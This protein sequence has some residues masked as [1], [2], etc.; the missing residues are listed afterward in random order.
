MLAG[1]PPTVFFFFTMSSL[2]QSRPCHKSHT[3]FEPPWTK[4]WLEWFSTTRSHNSD[5][6]VLVICA[7]KDHSGEDVTSKTHERILTEINKML[8]ALDAWLIAMGTSRPQ[9]EPILNAVL[10]ENGILAQ[11]IS[12]WTATVFPMASMVRIDRQE[13]I[14]AI[15]RLRSQEFSAWLLAQPEPSAE[16]LHSL[17]LGM[18][19]MLPKLGHHFLYS[20]KVGPR[21]RHGGRDPLLTEEQ[22]KQIPTEV[23][24]HARAEFQTGSN[25]QTLGIEI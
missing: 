17:L 4:T 14:G 10:R 18:R 16:E 20:G 11:F 6:P 13:A 19:D 22:K 1:W 23:K 24:A 21:Y 25:L 12:D 8:A 7:A 3:E 5:R 9:I 15:D 2:L